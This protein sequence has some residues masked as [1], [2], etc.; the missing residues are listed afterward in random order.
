MLDF[1]ELTFGKTLGHSTVIDGAFHAIL[2]LMYSLQKLLNLFVKSGPSLLYIFFKMMYS[3]SRAGR[4]SPTIGLS[5]AK[6]RVSLTSI[7]VAVA[8]IYMKVSLFC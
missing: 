2:R 7:K 3:F 8:C 6:L 4:I 1:L 5:A